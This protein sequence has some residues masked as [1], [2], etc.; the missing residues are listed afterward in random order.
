MNNDEANEHIANILAKVTLGREEA[1]GGISEEEM[2]DQ[3]RMEAAI[4]MAKSF[5]AGN[6]SN[7]DAD[8][9]FK[10]RGTLLVETAAS[11]LERHN[12]SS[13][14]VPIVSRGEREGDLVLELARRAQP[15]DQAAA[16]PQLNLPGKIKIGELVNS[17]CTHPTQWDGITDNMC[18]VYIRYRHGEL[19]VDIGAP[20]EMSEF[21]AHEGHLVFSVE[22]YDPRYGDGALPYVA[23][24]EL[25]KERFEVPADQVG[26]SS[27]DF[28]ESRAALVTTS[29]EPLPFP[30]VCET[31]N[32]PLKWDEHYLPSKEVPISVL[33]CKTCHKEPS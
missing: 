26:S 4:N 17:G 1:L 15:A 5:A 19:T 6:T 23:L 20:G 32:A 12:L 8:A 11:Y 27:A 3:I 25:L 2:K 16:A 30:F 18:K 31:C 33:P 10:Q 22:Y 7:L 29:G 28:P 24:K 9:A 13:L 21:A 14:L